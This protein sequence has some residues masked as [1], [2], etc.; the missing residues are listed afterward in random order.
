MFSQD[1][2]LLHI[3]KTVTC[4][5]MVLILSLTLVKMQHITYIYI[6]IEKYIKRSVVSCLVLFVDYRLG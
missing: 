5:K 6:H 4:V 3:R 2:A 1:V